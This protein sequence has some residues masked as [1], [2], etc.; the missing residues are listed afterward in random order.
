MDYD[1]PKSMGK[2]KW[3]VGERCKLIINIVRGREEDWKK[4]ITSEWL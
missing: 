1:C 4:T 3:N 2:P